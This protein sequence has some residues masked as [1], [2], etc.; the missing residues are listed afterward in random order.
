MAESV[1][2]GGWIDTH[3]HLDAREFDA[4]RDAVIRRAQVAGLAH[5]VIP[6]V[7]RNNFETVRELAHATTGAVYALGIHPMYV[8]QADDAD[9]NALKAA[10]TKYRDDS[11]LVAV[12][13]IGLD[14]FV[15]GLD[16]EKQQRFF[17]FQLQLARELDLPVIMHV[18]RAQDLVLKH[19]RQIRVKSGIAHA[20]NGS[21]QQADQFCQ[22]GCVLG[23]GGALTFE[24]ALQIRR[25]L[26]GIDRSAIVLETDSP[27]IAP[28]WH[29][30]KRNEPG[31]LP[32]IANVAAELLN[33]SPLDLQSLARVN[34]FRAL[35]RM[36]ALSAQHA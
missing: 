17:R 9:L 11:R 31:E 6:A 16:M 29:Y 1:V 34:T 23:F 4:D 33:I 15:P 30:R 8:Q 27:D 20:F 26:A 35:P 18:R 25:L 32:A 14:G 28:S 5:I 19:L 21:F 22:L 3:C 36:A 12:G 24:R 7:E 2:Q 13:E 10:L